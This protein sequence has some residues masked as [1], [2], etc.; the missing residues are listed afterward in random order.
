MISSLAYTLSFW[1]VQSIIIIYQNDKSKNNLT[2]E[3]TYVSE[4]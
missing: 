3:Q 4:S 1:K 2:S